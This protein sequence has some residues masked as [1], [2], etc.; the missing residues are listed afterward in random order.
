VITAR[1]PD[2]ARSWSTRL[3]PFTWMPLEQVTVLAHI[4]E[5]QRVTFNRL[6][7]G[8]PDRSFVRLRLVY[9]PPLP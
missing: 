1:N 5:Y 9:N 6:L 2:L 8:N 3:D 7:P 4:G